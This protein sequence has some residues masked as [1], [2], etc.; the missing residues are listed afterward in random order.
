MEIKT[1]EFQSLP[2]EEEVKGE[3]EEEEEE[4]KKE[5]VMEEKKESPEIKPANPEETQADIKTKEQFQVI[6]GVFLETRTNAFLSADHD[7]SR[8]ILMKFNRPTR[9]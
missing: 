8:N 4:R 2:K 6:M 3:K 1:K 9:E 7:F 5:D